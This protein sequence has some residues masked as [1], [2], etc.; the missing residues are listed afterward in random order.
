MHDALM[1]SA[2]VFDYTIYC[3]KFNKHSLVSLSANAV[4]RLRQTQ[5][6]K[7]KKKKRKLRIDLVNRVVNAFLF[8]LLSNTQSTRLQ[9]MVS[10]FPIAAFQL[11]CNANADRCDATTYA[12]AIILPASHS[13]RH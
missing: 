5:N 1:A 10:N 4:V 7:K 6:K 11:E 13:D 2:S 8:T 12:D 9:R 3:E